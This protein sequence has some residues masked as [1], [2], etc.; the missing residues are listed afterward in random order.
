M[1]FGSLSVMARHYSCLSGLEQG[2]QLDLKLLSV[3][4]SLAAVLLC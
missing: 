3:N 1:V 4:H 2:A